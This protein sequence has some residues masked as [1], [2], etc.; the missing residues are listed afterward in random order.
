MTESPTCQVSLLR[1][2][3]W[4]IQRNGQGWGPSM[5]WNLGVADSTILSFSRATD[6]NWSLLQTVRSLLA[7]YVNQNWHNLPPRYMVAVYWNLYGLYGS[8]PSSRMQNA[9]IQ[10][11][12]MG[13][14]APVHSTLYTPLLQEC[15]RNL[16][17]T[18]GSY[19]NPTIWKTRI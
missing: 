19:L 4:H 10:G 14:M 12:K 16:F 3:G 1:Q 17:G 2:A 15:C 8:S 6:T 7:D 9:A 5:P 18:V 11:M 13:Y